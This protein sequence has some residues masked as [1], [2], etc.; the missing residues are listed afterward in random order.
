MGET[1]HCMHTCAH[2]SML[3]SKDSCE[4]YGWDSRLCV[5]VCA[6]MHTCAHDSMLNR[7]GSCESYGWECVCMYIHRCMNAHVSMCIGKIYLP[8][9]L[10]QNYPYLPQY[11][12]KNT[13]YEVRYHTVYIHSFIFIF[14]YKYA[15]IRLYSCILEYTY[16]HTYTHIK[17]H[18]DTIFWSIRLSMYGCWK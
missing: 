10:I 16:I 6:C 4:L 12:V 7:K 5:Y 13:W 9:F 2:D 18:T 1:L 8:P 11:L 14:T 3:N 15:Y 17:I